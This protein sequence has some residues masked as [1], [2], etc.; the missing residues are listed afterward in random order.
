MWRCLL[1]ALYVVLCR[2]S[3]SQ[4][5]ASNAESLFAAVGLVCTYG[6]QY[7]QVGCAFTKPFQVLKQALEKDRLCNYSQWFETLCFLVSRISRQCWEQAKYH[8]SIRLANDSDFCVYRTLLETLDSEMNKSSGEENRWTFV[9][10]SSLPQILHCL[11][12]T[13]IVEKK[14]TSTMRIHI[15]DK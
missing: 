15:Y 1:V 6:L 5:S 8:L 2:I 3:V 12:N 7:R 14:P 9:F 10:P 11:S 13:C 4:P